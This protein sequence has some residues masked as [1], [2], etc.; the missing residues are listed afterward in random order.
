[1]INKV[2]AEN[3]V[4]KMMQGMNLKVNVMDER[5]VIVASSAKERVGDFHMIAYEIIQNELPMMI[6]DKPTRELIGVNA[7]GINLRLVSN[8]ET[9][10]VIGVSGNPAE[11]TDIAKMVKLTF[12]TMYEYEYKKGTGSKSS[13]NIWDFAHA[14]LKESPVN[15]YSIERMAKKLGYTDQLPRIPVYIQIRSEHRSTVI[16]HFIEEYGSLEGSRRQDIAIPVETGVLLMK[17]L[18]GNDP[19]SDEK[20]FI[21]DTIMIIE[22]DFLTRE[23]TGNQLL[24]Y[25]FLIGP[26]LNRFIDYTAV[27]QHLLWLSKQMLPETE[28]LH[29]LLDYLPELFVW[30]DKE[31][32]LT[33][34]FAHY[35]QLITNEMDRDVFIETVRALALADM[36]LDIAARSLHLHKNSVSARL[37]KIKELL[38]IHPAASPR[39]AIFLFSLGAFMQKQT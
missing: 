15:E 19:G 5:G 27:Y 28:R 23:G 26:V 25:Q 6:T 31:E 36:K 24:G 9:I 38:A 37:K 16:Q 22:R 34:L 13:N 12:E 2:F 1:M 35:Q 39:D 7:P 14:L 18:P 33:P 8:R 11:L 3:F 10:G 17:M 20:A 4:R 32:L 29:F 30:S 21:R